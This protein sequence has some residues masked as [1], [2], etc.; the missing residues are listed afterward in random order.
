MI[1]RPPRSTLFPYTTLF[2]SSEPILYEELTRSGIPPKK[3]VQPTMK[4]VVAAHQFMRDAIEQEELSHYNQPL[5]NQTV[6]IT[7]ERAFGRYG[8][9]GWESMSKNLSTSALDAATFALWGQRVFKKRR[10]SNEDKKM[11]K[12]RWQQIVSQL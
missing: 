5:L 7:K 4:E 11:N 9:F 2:R 1:R 10:Q 3:I 8:G 6:R 12:E